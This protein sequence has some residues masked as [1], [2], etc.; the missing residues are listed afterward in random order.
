MGNAL[1]SIINGPAGVGFALLCGRLLP[2]R[3]AQRMIAFLAAHLT[4]QQDLPLVQAVRANQM[5]ISGET[6]VSPPTDSPHTFTNPADQAVYETFCYAGRF[7]YDLYHYQHRET[8]VQSLVSFTPPATALLAR[9]AS[10]TE[11]TI[12]VAPHLGNFDLAARAATQRN[13][14]VQMISFPQPGN[15]YRWQNRMRRQAGLTITPASLTAL[16]AARQRLQNEGN[17]VTGVDRPVPDRKYCPHFF[18]HPAALPVLHI[19]LAL[20]TQAPIFVVGAILRADGVYEVL[21]SGPITIE[22]HADRHAEIITNAER[23]LHAAAD[24]IR[25]APRQWMMFYPVWS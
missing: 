11:R 12:V 15:G 14:S 17:V 7:L 16:R 13:I 10:E 4:R 24:L 20:K 1:Q 21:A 19:T 3:P 8:A 23:V 9:L 25:Q 5:M 22:P 6:A 18:D 2:L